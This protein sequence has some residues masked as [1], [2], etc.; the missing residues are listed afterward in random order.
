MGRAHSRFARLLEEAIAD[1]SS[2]A[3]EWI[4]HQI[5]SGVKVAA[6]RPMAKILMDA[7]AEFDAAAGEAAILIPV[8]IDKARSVRANISLDAGLLEAIDEAAQL[9]G[10]TRSSFL[11]SAAREKIAE[12]K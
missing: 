12:A 11:A 3:R 5:A 6:P 4:S 7:S 10:L 2:A 9:R 1:A 8:I